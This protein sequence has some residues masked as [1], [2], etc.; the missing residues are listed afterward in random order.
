M[1]DDEWLAHV[2]REAALAVGAWLEGRGRL[3]QPIRVLTIAELEGL[4]SAAIARYVV[5]GFERIRDTPEKAENLRW[6]LAG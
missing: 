1:S 5:L 2:T 3:H 4:A 6:L